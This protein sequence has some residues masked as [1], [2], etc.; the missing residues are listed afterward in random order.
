MSEGNASKKT[1]TSRCMFARCP[2]RGRAARGERAA[3][4]AAAGDSTVLFGYV[5]GL[6]DVN[7]HGTTFSNACFQVLFCY[8][9]EVIDVDLMI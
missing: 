7:R 6:P 9:L 1:P 2:P 5:E 3:A 4:A 8:S